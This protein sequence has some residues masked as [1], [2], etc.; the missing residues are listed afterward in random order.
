MGGGAP[1]DSVA[2]DITGECAAGDAGG[3][4]EVVVVMCTI[5]NRGWRR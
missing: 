3:V 1:G 4:G 5:V 2:D